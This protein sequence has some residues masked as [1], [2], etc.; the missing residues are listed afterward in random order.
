MPTSTAPAFMRAIARGGRRLHAQHEVGIAQSSAVAVVD[1][2]RAGI[3]VSLVGKM[4]TVAEAALDR[5]PAR[6]RAT[7]FLQ[8]SGVS[9][10]R[11]SPGAVSRAT[12]MIIRHAATPP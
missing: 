9:A 5:A 10:T 3:G 12:A 2:L 6:R 1:Q 8:V 4:R 7:S 11:R